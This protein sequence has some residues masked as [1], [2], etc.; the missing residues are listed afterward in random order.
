MKGAINEETMA[1][2]AVTKIVMTEA[3]PEMATQPMDSPYVVLG[4]PP[5]TAPTIEPTPSPSSVRESPGSRR[6]SVPM[7]EEMFLWSAICSA[8][9]TNATGMYATA[10]VPIY[11][12]I[13]PPAGSSS[14]PNISR[15]VNPG[16]H[17]IDWNTVKS[18][19]RISSAPGI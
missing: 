11:A 14:P 5:N 8:N 7:M 10:I 18:M 6:R 2:S 3:F 1:N 15:K 9:T 17:S 19:M 16:S 12:P 4:Q 13:L